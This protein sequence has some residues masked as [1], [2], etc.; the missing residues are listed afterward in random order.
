MVGELGLSNQWS[1]RFDTIAAPA[2]AFHARHAVDAAKP[3]QLAT[4]RR[5]FL[6]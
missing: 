3:K 1:I 2:R 4:T 5:D 6:R